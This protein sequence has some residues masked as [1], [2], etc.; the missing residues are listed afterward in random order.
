MQ[1][2]T[3]CV[4]RNSDGEFVTEVIGE[5]ISFG[6]AKNAK[7]L[8]YGDAENIKDKHHRLTMFEVDYEKGFGFYIEY[9]N[10]RIKI[11]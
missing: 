4:L 2:W 9:K 10:D 1:D 5:K 6:S 7:F 3:N 8:I 11:K